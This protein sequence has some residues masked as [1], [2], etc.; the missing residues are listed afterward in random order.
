MDCKKEK[1]A[2][3]ET[4]MPE[5]YLDIIDTQVE[6]FEKGATHEVRN[7]IPPTND[8]PLEDPNRWLKIPDIICV[9]VDMIGSTQF[10]AQKHDNSTANAYQFFTGTAVRLFHSFEAPYIDVRGDGVFALFNSTQP[11][12]ALASAVT[13]KTFVEEVFTPKIKSK[14]G[15]EIGS[16]IGIDQKTVL[17]R[18]IGLKSHGGRSDRRN[19]V[20][21]GKPINMAAK[22]ASRSKIEEL[23]VSNRYFKQLKDEHA[24]KSCGC[25]A[26]MKKNLWEEVDLKDN[27]LFDFDTGYLLKAIWCKTHG[28]EYCEH[29]VALDKG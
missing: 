17:V 28:A 24:I 13:F 12:R 8:I 14:T 10:S 15:L 2:M 27:E 7:S 18:K 6:V 19:E 22:L 5:R 29:I 4:Q 3:T 20:W 9:Y 25:N 23:L 16:H 21:A 11:Y 26:G 1:E